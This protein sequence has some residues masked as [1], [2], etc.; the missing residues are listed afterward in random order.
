MRRALG[1]GLSQLIADQFEGGPSEVPL[2]AIE[3]NLRQPRRHFD[4]AALEDLA[5][6]IRQHGVIQPLLVRPLTEGRYELIAGERRLRAAKIA[7][8]T[9]VP[10]IV[11]SAGNQNSLELA[12]IENLQ[13]E[14]I[15][16]VE[17]ALA[18]RRLIDEFGI[19]QEQAADKVGKS[20]TAVANTLR[21]LKLPAKILDGLAEG[22]ITEG[23]ARALLGIPNEAHQLVVYDA[24]LERN[25]TVREV[26]RLAQATPREKPVKAKD[27]AKL[28]PNMRA[29]QELLSTTLGSPTRILP[30]EVG[31]KLQIEYYS[32]EDLQR[33]LEVLGVSS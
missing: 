27:T 17:C 2:D 21:L 26:E 32:D 23:H 5:S 25:L 8:L 12:L 10:V 30:G 1:K 11:R 20:R 24:I 16:P 31:G 6:S 9:V 4:A 22:K 15:G 28:D 7:G 33:I 19:T 3:P 13:R 18:Y 14:D 29:L